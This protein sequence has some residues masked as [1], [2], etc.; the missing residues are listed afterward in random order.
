MEKQ[1]ELQIH[2][3]SETA[4]VIIRLTDPDVGDI[5]SNLKLQKLL[6]YVQGFH[7]A[8]FDK[9][10]FKE[11]IV[12]WEY[13]PVVREVYDEYKG[14]GKGAIPFPDKNFEDTLAQEQF[15]LMVDVYHVYGQ[16]TAVRLMELTHEELPWINTKKNEVISPK[17]MK[18]YFLTQLTD[19]EDLFHIPA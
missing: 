9:P 16:Y 6:Y 17:L 14:Y 1:N 5:I 10:L 2:S 19:N 3:A 15:D 13:G 12:A 18:S 4:K 8:V 11:D 7:L